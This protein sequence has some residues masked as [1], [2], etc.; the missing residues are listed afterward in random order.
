MALTTKSASG[1]VAT[2]M[3]RGS[4]ALWAVLRRPG[5]PPLTRQE[6]ALIGQEMTLDDSRIREELGFRDAVTVEQGLSDLAAAA[7]TAD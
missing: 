4:E 2:A 1:W 6:L 5:K 3:A 7:P